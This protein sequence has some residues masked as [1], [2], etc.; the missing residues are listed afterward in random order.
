MCH[1]SHVSSHVSCVTYHVTRNM[2]RVTCKKRKRKKKKKKRKEWWSQSVEGLLSIRP[3]PSSLVMNKLT[4][5]TSSGA[6]Q[7]SLKSSAFVRLKILLILLGQFQQESILLASKYLHT[8]P[9]FMQ[10]MLWFHIL[11][12]K[13]K[14]NHHY[15]KQFLAFILQKIFKVKL[16]C[17]LL[18]KTNQIRHNQRPLATRF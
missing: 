13:E 10:M 14:K 7:S 8:K 5:S 18:N 16:D 6:I 4:V 3:T 15:P 1:M 2:S 17:K 11:L 12:L 9:I